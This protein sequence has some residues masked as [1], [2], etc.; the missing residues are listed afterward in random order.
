MSSEGLREK[1][2]HISQSHL[3]CRGTGQRHDKPA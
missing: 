1:F 3:D 2:L